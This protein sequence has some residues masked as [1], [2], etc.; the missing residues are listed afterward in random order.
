MNWIKK[1]FTISDKIKKILKKRPTK[2]DIENSKWISCCGPI[3]K[4]DLSDN[5]WVCNKCGR[6]H[7]V[8]STE[9]FNIF[10]GKNNYEIL[11]TPIPKD[12]PLKWVDS[13]K[14]IDRLN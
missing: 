7:K 8:S 3:L 6:H 14:Y 2:E 1:V 11:K 13:K 9:R 4:T 12:D 5:Q 10:F